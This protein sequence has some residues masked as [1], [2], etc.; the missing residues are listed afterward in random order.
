MVA[1]KFPRS[2][3]L[4][5]SSDK[6]LEEGRSV[7]RLDHPS[8]VKVYNIEETEDG[9]PFA[10]MEYIEGPTLHQVINDEGLKFS[11]AITLLIQIAEALDYAHSRT[12]IHRDLKPSNVIITKERDRAKLMDFGMALHDL[13]PEESLLD[14]PEGTPPYMAPEQIRGENHRLDRRTDIWGF[15]AMMY[16]MLTGQRPFAGKDLKL[17]A[18][19]IC[20]SDPTPPRRINPDVPNELERIC[21]KCLEKLMSA[22]DQSRRNKSF[23]TPDTEFGQILAAMREPLMLEL[24]GKG[25]ITDQQTRYLATW[26]DFDRQHFFDQLEALGTAL[27]S[28]P[29]VNAP[30]VVIDQDENGE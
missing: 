10:V 3:R 18:S 29:F 24:P 28:D 7:A 27:Q 11:V 16:V 1:I 14:I 26:R 17:L 8:I 19:K 2:D 6:F 4:S 23:Q 5:F 15:G 25:E 21:L 30:P 22:R 13:T 20:Q 12:L 9:L